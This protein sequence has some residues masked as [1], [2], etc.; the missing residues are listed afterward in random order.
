MGFCMSG[1]K[2]EGAKGGDRVVLRDSCG[3][4]VEDFCCGCEVLLRE[5]GWI[6]HVVCC[7]RE[8][9]GAVFCE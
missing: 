5:G 7:S 4:L 1:L 6:C 2:V 8:L 3:G 9:E